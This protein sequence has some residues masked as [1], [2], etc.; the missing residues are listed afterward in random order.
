MNETVLLAVLAS[1]GFWA[2]VLKVVDYFL[3]RRG[4]NSTERAALGALIRHDMFEIYDQY[5]DAPTVPH[6]I[7]EEIDSLYQAYKSM[8]FNNMGTKIHDEI[9]KKQT[10]V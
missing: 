1:S 7:Q 4:K 5:K 3:S 6:A 10:E 8:G 9:M 2:V